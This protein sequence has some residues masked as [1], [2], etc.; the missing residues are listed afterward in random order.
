MGLRA[1]GKAMRQS[2][3]GHVRAQRP[4]PRRQ[5]TTPVCDQCMERCEEGTEIRIIVSQDGELEDEKVFCQRECFWDYYETDVQ[6]ARVDKAKR[7][8]LQWLHEKVCPVCKDRLRT[9]IARGDVPEN[10]EG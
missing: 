9:C 2:V 5:T 4:N 8:E 6:D 1:P 3:V 7:D 10:K